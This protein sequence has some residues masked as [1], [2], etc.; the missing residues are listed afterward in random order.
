MKSFFSNRLVLILCIIFLLIIGVF[1]YRQFISPKTP[2]VQNNQEEAPINENIIT[3]SGKVQAKREANLSFPGA[4]GQLAWV[5][6]VEGSRI[7]KGQ[8][9]ASLDQRIIDKNLQKYLNLFMTNRWDFEQLQDNYKSKR[10][11]FLLT[12]QDKRILDKAQFSLNNAV[13]DVEIADLAQK[14]AVLI[15]PI[16]GIVT[17]ADASFPGEIAGPT[18]IFTITDTNSIYFN[19]NIDEADISKIKVGQEVS[20]T[21]DAYPN[22]TFKGK[23]VQIDFVSTSTAGGGTAFQVEVS[24]PAN[25]NLKFKVGMNG[26]ADIDTQ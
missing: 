18:T 17:R 10:E 19:A 3:V 1:A 4:G 9:I 21:L 14:Q 23:V 26:D 22:E 7:L 5:G 12:D 25:E 13:I 16:S 6:I 24:L 20:M 11:N 2:E 8:G 15:S